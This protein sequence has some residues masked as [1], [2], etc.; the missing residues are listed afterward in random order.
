MPTIPKAHA[1]RGDIL[2]PDANEDYPAPLPPETHSTDVALVNRKVTTVGH[3]QNSKPKPLYSN[4]SVNILTL[5]F[6]PTHFNQ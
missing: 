1:N 2:N 5:A 3:A 4:L 6:T